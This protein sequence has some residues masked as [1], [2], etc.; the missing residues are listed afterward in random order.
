[1]ED[2]RPDYPVFTIEQI[3]PLL[4]RAALYPD[5]LSEDELRIADNISVGWFE[6]K[7]KEGAYEQKE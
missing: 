7:E 1:M 3:L 6:L 5:S 4:F 2:I